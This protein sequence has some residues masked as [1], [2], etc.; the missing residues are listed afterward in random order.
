MSN[1]T[2]CYYYMASI[3]GIDS[4]IFKRDVTKRDGTPGHFVSVLGVAVKV[5]DYWEYSE[6]YQ[7]AM[8]QAFAKVNQIPDYQY[9]CVDD[10]RNFSQKYQ[11]LDSFVKEISCHIEKVHVFYTLFSKQRL[12]TVKVFGRLAQREKIK[13]AAPTRTYEE[14]V[15]KYLLHCFPVVCAWKLTEYLF[16][17]TV[18]FHL[19]SYG[20]NICEAQEYLEKS[21]FTYYVYP[22]GDCSNPVISTADLLLDVLDNRLNINNKYLLFDN[23]RPTFPEFGENLLV[24]PILNKHL[25]VIN[26]LDNKTIDTTPKLQ[27][28]VFWVFKGDKLIES[29]TMK[30]SKTYRNLIDYASAKLGVV[31][32]FESGKDINF[33]QEGDYGVYINNMG[34]EI[35]DSYIKL[36]KCFI[37]FDMDIMVQKKD[38]RHNV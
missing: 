10:M 32:M 8:K 21:G 26:P 22:S 15:N 38:I 27:H 7:E 14:L 16:P 3:I 12:E 13:L 11:I 9:Y 33:V 23:I 34:K 36:G 37:P 18:R 5:G 29:S 1:F 24:Y 17:E 20:G 6:M 2:T 30:K 4:R 28:P 35:V 19:D 25:S 31:K